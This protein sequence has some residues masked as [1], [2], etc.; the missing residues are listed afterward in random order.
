[1][2]LL[3]SLH[4]AFSRAR[5]LAP[6][7]FLHRSFLFLFLTLTLLS[8][9]APVAPEPSAAWARDALAKEADYIVNCSFTELTRNNRGIQATEDAYGWAPLPARS[10]KGIEGEVELFQLGLPGSAAPDRP[11]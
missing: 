7:A 10:L 11:A 4:P 3:A 8:I 1:M 2:S 6:R 5:T 9:R